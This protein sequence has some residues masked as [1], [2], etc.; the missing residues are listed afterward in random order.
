MGT[1]TERGDL[2]IHLAKLFSFI[3]MLHNAAV[4]NKT[5]AVAFLFIQ[6]ISIAKF[7]CQIQRRKAKKKQEK[8]KKDYYFWCAK[9]GKQM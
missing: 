4:M 8:E 1:D 3:R 9:I 6:F 5:Y 7:H 2:N